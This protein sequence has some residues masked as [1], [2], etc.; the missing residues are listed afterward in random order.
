[1]MPLSMRHL[2][3]TRAARWAMIAAAIGLLVIGLLAVWWWSE[4]AER[5]A[6]LRLSAQERA[7]LYRR[8]IET[9]ETL[10]GRGPRGDAL[11]NECARRAAFVLQ[12]PECDDE[13]KTLARSH[14]PT[15]TR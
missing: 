7:E 3:T 12:F 11:H 5:R 2:R 13:C 15:G 10:C 14:L 8:E 9:L 4:G 1:M 6:I